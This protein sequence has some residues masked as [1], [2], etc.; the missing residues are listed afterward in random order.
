MNMNISGSPKN[1]MAGAITSP[2]VIAEGRY[3]DLRL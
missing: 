2:L 3:T 1:D